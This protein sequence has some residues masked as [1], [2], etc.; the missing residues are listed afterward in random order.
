MRFYTKVKKQAKT[1]IIYVVG[2][3]KTIAKKA[4][5]SKEKAD[6]FAKRQQICQYKIGRLSDK[7]KKYEERIIK[8]K[9]KQLVHLQRCSDSDFLE[10]TKIKVLKIEK[11]GKTLDG[12]L[13]FFSKHKWFILPPVYLG[14]DEEIA[15][16][17]KV[18]LVEIGGIIKEKKLSRKIL[19]KM[20][21]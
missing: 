16:G 13:R 12:G 15:K 20:N 14:K 11:L 5:L 18:E 2:D 3:S 10:Q 9:E 4:E 19:G 6:K 8:Q 1:S 21:E 17:T 7:I